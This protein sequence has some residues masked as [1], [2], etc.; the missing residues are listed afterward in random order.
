MADSRFAVFN[1]N[2]VQNLKQNATNQNTNKSPQ[3]WIA[4]WR[5][6]AEIRGV[7]P[8]LEEHE[9]ETLDLDG[10]TNSKLV[11]KLFILFYY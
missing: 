3:T 11:L 4:V 2:E 1:E 9:P 8:I 10:F 6:W 5:S 7:N